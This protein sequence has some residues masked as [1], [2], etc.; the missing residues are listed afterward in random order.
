[1]KNRILTISREFGSGGR[2][3]GRQTAARL[4]LPCYDQELIAQLARESGFT[5]DY[6]AEQ[7]EYA[8][9]GGWLAN[10]LAGRSEQ[11][12][13]SQ[14]YL[15]IIQRQMILALAEKGP[16]VIVGRCA[17]F[18]LQDAADCLTA[19]VHAAPAWRAQRIA[20]VYGETAQAPEKRVLEKD[21]RRAAYYQFY[22]DRK[23]GQAR[24]YDIA[25]DSG[26][27]G[28]DRCTELFASLF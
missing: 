19:F 5:E 12:V 8:L 28:I 23:W 15:W 21:K 7:S 1:M 2:T 11:G 20:A 6:V 3:I 25:L 22:T 27:L 17:D 13:S 14:D 26:V 4:D 10:A 9:R 16:C 18:I 24:Y